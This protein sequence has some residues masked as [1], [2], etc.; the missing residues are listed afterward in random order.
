MNFGDWLMHCGDVPAAN[1][2]GLAVC[3]G[4]AAFWFVIVWRACR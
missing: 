3:L 2:L 4:F 1:W